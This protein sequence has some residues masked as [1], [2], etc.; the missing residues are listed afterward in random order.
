ML[1]LIS[2]T[3][4]SSMAFINFW[5]TVPYVHVAHLYRL[6]NQPSCLNLDRYTKHDV[7]LCL[8]AFWGVNDL[9][10]SATCPRCMNTVFIGFIHM[11]VIAE[12]FV[13]LT[14]LTSSPIAISTDLSHNAYYVCSPCLH[15]HSPSI[16]T[17]HA[18]MFVS[19]CHIGGHSWSTCINVNS[20]R[21]RT[22]S[23]CYL[24]MRL[25]EFII[26]EKLIKNELGECSVYECG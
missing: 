9:S 21:T 14:K 6:L 16:T 13:Y 20:G 15:K 26:L 22:V 7:G 17:W 24:L 18:I 3:V 11:K 8:F 5:N 12:T 25:A 23:L 4:Y 2:G 10:Y 19:G 1:L